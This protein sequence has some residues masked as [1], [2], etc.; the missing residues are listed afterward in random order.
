M[1]NNAELKDMIL[2]L[3]TDYYLESRDFNGISLDGIAAVLNDTAVISRRRIET[4]VRGLVTDEKITLMFSSTSLNPHIKRLPALPKEEQLE[5]LEGGG[6]ICAYPTEAV[7][8]TAVDES[9]YQ[10]RPFTKRLLLGEPQLT[11]VYFDLHVLER[12]SSDPR[13]RYNFNGYCGCISVSDDYFESEQMPRRDRAFLQTFGVGYD[14]ESN[15]VVVVFLCYLSDLSPEHQQIWHAHIRA[16]ECKMIYEYYQNS[17]LGEWAEGVSVYQA[18]TELQLEIN[19]LAAIIGLPPLF[20]QTY[21]KHPRGFSP[22][23]RPTLKSLQDFIHLLDKM[24]SD[25]IN[26]DFFLKSLELEEQIDREDGRVEVRRKGTLALLD[27]WLHVTVRFPDEEAYRTIVEP[28]RDVRKRR[29]K[30]AHVVMDDSYS[31]DYTRQQDELVESV[32]YALGGLCVV[33]STHPKARAAGYR[34]PDWFEQSK[35]KVY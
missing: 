6:G 16:D 25:N 17:I 18:I 2:A 29:Q 24:L 35:V 32:Y 7:I 15:R 11:P 21:S 10:D 12:Y 26:K 9:D 28:L 4:A 27:E 8:R 23:L 19:R 34:L 5:R 22:L 1:L 20:R 14:A 33:M 31:A 30:P 13:F 3:V